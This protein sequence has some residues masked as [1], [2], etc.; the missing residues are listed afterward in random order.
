[1]QDNVTFTKS[2]NR[3]AYV[4]SVMYSNIRSNPP[5]EKDAL[6]HIWRGLQEKETKGM[7]D[8]WRCSLLVERVKELMTIPCWRERKS[9]SCIEEWTSNGM[10]RVSKQTFITCQS[11]N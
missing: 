7:V 8:I 4:F 9:F 10:H 3:W 11:L 2:P 5:L 1:M 6:G